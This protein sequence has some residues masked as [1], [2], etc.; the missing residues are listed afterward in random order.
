MGL[1]KR[2]FGQPE[3]HSV[4]GP[5]AEH[6]T[7]A[8]AILRLCEIDAERRGDDQW[9]TFAASGAGR[10][11][12]IQVSG[13]KVNFLTLEVPLHELL[14]AHEP[15]LVEIVSPGGRR[16]EDRTLWIVDPPAPAAIARIVH[17][18]FVHACGLGEGYSVEG[19]RDG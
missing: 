15:G 12:T 11:A 4:R 19:N 9:L 18:A 5:S 6:P 3:R 16:G 2:L 8:A 13:D 10:S 17:L 1:L 7:A 14:A